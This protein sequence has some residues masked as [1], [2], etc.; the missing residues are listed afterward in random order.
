MTL[1][2]KT[3]YAFGFIATL[4]VL[5]MGLFMLGSAEGILEDTLRQEH[6][7]FIESVS[8][9]LTTFLAST[10]SEFL[11]TVQEIPFGAIEG[12]EYGKVEQYLLQAFRTHPRFGGGFFVLDKN[13]IL[14]ASAPLRLE[15]IGE[16]FHLKPYFKKT[17]HSR[18]PVIWG[19]HRSELAQLT[20]LTY[21]MPLLTYTGEFKGLLGGSVQISYKTALGSLREVH[22]G[23]KG[24]LTVS[25][26]TGRV[27][28]SSQ[29]Q[30]AGTETQSANPEEMIETS[31]D[32]LPTT[33]WIITVHEPR[34]QAF[35]PIRQLRNH[36]LIILVSA[37][38]FGILLGCW[39]A[40][41]LVRPL[42]RLQERVKNIT[43]ADLS[44]DL[45]EITG[46]D[47]IGDLAK[48]FARM[49]ENL[50]AA[51][52]EITLRAEE[53]V[54]AR[55]KAFDANRAK[56]Q[57]LANM[58]HEIR[59]PMNA[60]TG[61]TDMLLDT[62]LTNEQ[63]D[64]AT[65]VKRSGEDL[66]SLINDILDF[67][68]IE[69]GELDFEEIDFDPELLAYDV[70]DAVRPRIGSKS[71]ELLC[72]IEDAVPASVK[73]DPTRFKQVLINLMGNAPKFMDSGEIELSLHIEEETERR[74]KLHAKI[75]DTG[76]GIPSGKLDLIFDSFSQADGSTTRKYGGTGLGLSI[77]RQIS[78]LMDG[79]VWA[80]SEEGKGSIFHFTAWLEKST[81]KSAERYTPALLT[82][83]RILIIDDN[84]TNLEILTRNLELVGMRVVA[85]RS[86][87]EVLPALQKSVDEK[88]PFDVCISD[89]QMPGL[90]G[91]ETAERIRESDSPLSNI[92]LIALSS[93]IERD[94]RRC[95]EAGFDGFLNKPVRREKLYEMLAR[96]PG[97]KKKGG[98][99]RREIMTQYS[100]REEMKLSIRILLAEDNPVN[101]KL[102]KIMLG[103]GGYQV[104]VANNGKEAVQKYI[105]SPDDF[106]LIF[107][108]IQMPEMDGVEA[109]Q[110]IRKKGFD[111]VPIIA[112]TAHAMKG[113]REKCIQSGMNDY[114][115]KPIKR[116]V[117]FAVIE[118]WVFGKG[119]HD[120]LA[121]CQPPSPSSSVEKDLSS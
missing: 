17:M 22:F 49:T 48:T 80:E 15:F 10:Q 61:F 53:L 63:K 4:P 78:N 8:N 96:F 117:V 11:S 104:E 59:T 95:E 94:A 44:L 99:E 64:Y 33:G 58:S 121:R 88:D 76:I 68:K 79:D 62:Q 43:P 105:T 113:D 30:S 25:T 77:C 21:T 46:R 74:I 108:D 52:E 110:A 72:H 38:G 20:V 120:G 91:Y 27:I 97:E 42:K 73:G 115:S 107:M 16:G 29:R 100:V 14:V 9:R 60:V 92:R 5:I 98:E 70:C 2:T 12:K 82:G 3:L 93:V 13:G 57:F 119:K 56:S 35:A 85:L 71:I 36:G 109:C 19:P 41:L 118:K 116:E 103:K 31:S 1:R 114:V 47:E 50:S 18:S 90:S 66:L 51:Q 40:L 67:S 84:R 23:Q 45:S 24:Y 26:P 102:A 81:G 65:S 86:G 101:Q 54:V 83:K 106:D 87:E 6:E 7:V 34:S 75:R 89:I 37:L 112:M 55:D 69:A 111:T 28:V 39:A 32:P